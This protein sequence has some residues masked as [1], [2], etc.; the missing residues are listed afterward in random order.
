MLRWILRALSLA[1][2]TALLAEV[3]YV[4]VVAFRHHWWDAAAT[5]TGLMFLVAFLLWLDL[6]KLKKRLSMNL[7]SKEAIFGLDDRKYEIVSVP[8]WG[9]DVRLRSLTGAER[10]E[11]EV[12]MTRQVGNTQKVDA[13]NARAK[14]I[15]L[16]ACDVGGLPLFQAADV[17]K[18]G[19]K[20]SAALQRLFD[21]ACRLSGFSDEDLK[22]L[23]EGFEPAPNGAST[24]ASPHTSATP[25]ASSYA[26][27][28]PAS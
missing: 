5:F 4:A 12:G 22:E 21:A 19:T 15:A 27:S 2:G 10:D 24:S 9:G 25:S 18:L 6:R 11:Y 14:L 17:I 8:E 26:G 23:E 1:A 28:T 3:T 16:S 13:R 7:L 20:S